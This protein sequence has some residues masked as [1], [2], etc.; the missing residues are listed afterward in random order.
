MSEGGREPPGVELLSS[1][2][3][4]RFSPFSSSSVGFSVNW[5]IHPFFFLSVCFWHWKRCTMG[6]AQWPC[7]FVNLF[8]YCSKAILCQ[9][10]ILS[11]SN[12]LIATIVE[13]KPN[14][15]YRVDLSQ[16][17]CKI[18]PF[19]KLPWKGSFIA[20]FVLNHA[21]DSNTNICRSECNSSLFSCSR[22]PCSNI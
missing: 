16:L 15:L 17:W 5:R 20:I 22:D 14:A 9:S 7:S 10:F 6:L 4:L 13:K 11:K 2:L 18:F 12:R 21:V 8:A 3:L 1:S 19:W